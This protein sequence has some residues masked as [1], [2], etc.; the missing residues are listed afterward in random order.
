MAL[1]TLLALTGLAVTMR[2]DLVLLAWRQGNDRLRA[3]DYRGALSA[4]HRAAA[5]MPHV[6]PLAF[7]AGVAHYR[8][9]EY[10]EARSRFAAAAASADPALRGAARYNLGNCAFRQGERLVVTCRPAAMR[11][12]QEAVREYEQALAITPSAVDASHN[13]A[14]VRIRLAGLA[15]GEDRDSRSGAAQSGDRAGND[16]ARSGIQD[17]EALREGESSVGRRTE[18]D[19]ETA[20]RS[21]GDKSDSPAQSDK[22]LPKL[23]RDEAERLLNEARGREALSAAPTA[24]EGRG[25]LARPEKD[26]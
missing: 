24:K 4:L 21:P 15:G 23:T 25:R 3:G 12:F 5:G 9:G 6:L 17:E 1:I 18:H 8:L 20:G 26:W 13:L 22:A 14:V 2:H 19:K 16:T 11:L 7:N 10:Q